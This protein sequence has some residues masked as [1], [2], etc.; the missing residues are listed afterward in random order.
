M[1]EHDG[2][3][4]K[5]SASNPNLNDRIM[6]K[7][8]PEKSDTIFWYIKFNILLDESTV[9]DK[10][11]YVTDLAGYK[12]RTFIEYSEEYNVIS[13]SPIDTYSKDTYYILHISKRVKSKK[14]NKL[15]RKINIVFKLVN[16]EISSYEVLKDDHEV[17][18]PVPRPKNYDPDKVISKVYGF[19]NEEFNKEGKD[20]LPYLPFKINPFVGIVGLLIVIIGLI[21]NLYI[22][23]LGVFVS[24]LGVLHLV[25]QLRDD[26]KIATY[27]YNQGVKEFRAKNYQKAEKLFKKAFE[28]D[29]YNEHIEFAISRVKYYK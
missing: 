9:N 20:N 13:I 27:T 22:A 29:K 28:H 15:K 18:E 26:E 14:G 19:T 10:S 17:P 8:D 2:Q 21:V 12:M 6:Y 16:S 11:M 4:I 1:E 7:I 24:V 5:V 3:K 25:M 23:I